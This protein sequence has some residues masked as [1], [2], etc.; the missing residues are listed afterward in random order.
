LQEDFVNEKPMIQHFLEARGHVCIFYPKFHCELNPIEMLWGYGK[1]HEF[2]A[3]FPHCIWLIS[4]N[5]GFC[6]ASDGK[7]LTAKVLVPQCLDMADVFTIRHFFCKTWRYM[8]AYQYALSCLHFGTLLISLPAKDLMWNRLSLPQG[9]ISNTDR[10]VPSPRF[11][12]QCGYRKSVRRR[13][14][15]SEVVHQQ[16]RRS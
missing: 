8:D 12:M 5:A 14:R 9:N 3:P 7:F 1:H 15:T 10:L 16:A 11:W 6:A 13:L 2:R 4:S